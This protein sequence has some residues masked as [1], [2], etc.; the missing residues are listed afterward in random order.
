MIE[1]IPTSDSVTVGDKKYLWQQVHN[2]VVT[3]FIITSGVAEGQTLRLGFNYA[4]MS[5]GAEPREV[6][7]EPGAI[8]KAIRYALKL[9]WAPE[10]P[11]LVDFVVYGEELNL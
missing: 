9:G 4:A 1:T 10:E 11:G 6:K 2:D 3:D 8:E 5:S 7:L